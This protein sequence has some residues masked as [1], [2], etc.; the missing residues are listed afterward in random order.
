MATYGVLA[1]LGTAETP[2]RHCQQGRNNALVETVGYGIQSIQPHPMDV[3]T[4]YKSTSRIVEVNGNAPRAAT[5]TPSTTRARS[6]AA[7]ARASATPAVRCSSTTPT[8]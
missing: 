4:R 5:S 8:R 6:V 7:A 3:E 1:P 2:G